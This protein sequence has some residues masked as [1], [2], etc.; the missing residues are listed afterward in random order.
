MV[1]GCIQ[2]GTCFENTYLAG[3]NKICAKKSSFVNSY[4]FRDI[5]Y[6]CAV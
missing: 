1:P 5:L 6:F 4:G 3:F 2:N